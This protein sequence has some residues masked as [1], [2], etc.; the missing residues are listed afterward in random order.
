MKTI[1]RLH[2]IT[3]ETSSL[4]HLDTM[5]SALDSGVT[6]TQLRIKNESLSTVKKIAEQAKEL[7]LEYKA[8]LIINDYLEVCKEL[9]LD[10]VHLG[11]TDTSTKDAR[12]F[13][14]Q[15][16]IV[17]GTANTFE[18]IIYHY[19]NGVD[20]VGI[21]PYKFTSTKDKLSPIVGLEGYKKVL[22]SLDDEGIQVPLIAIGGITQDD[23]RGIRDVGMYGIAVASLINLSEK[24]QLIIESLNRNLNL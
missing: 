24:P 2:H 9:D 5:R 7:C 1:S 6:W 15:S 17:G 13:L 21:G 3:Q 22:K 23:V 8:T 18:D 19:K 10:G 11:L 4:T 16:K 20:Y 12:E 14:G